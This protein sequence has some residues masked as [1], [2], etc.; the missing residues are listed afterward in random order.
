[1]C[2]CLAAVAAVSG[3]P[4]VAIAAAGPAPERAGPAAPVPVPHVVFVWFADGGAPP[5]SGICGPAVPPPFRCTFAASPAACAGAVTRELR[6]LYQD[7]DLDFVTTDP[8]PAPH[9]TVVVTSAGGAWCAPAG[10]P[11]VRGVAPVNCRADG[12]FGQTAYVFACDRDAVGCAER[13][14]QE[15]AHLVGLDHSASPADVMFP[16]E[17]RGAE[18][19]DRTFPT[20]NPRC[21]KPT[22]NS[23][24]L[25]LARFGRHRRAR[26]A[27]SGHS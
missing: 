7:F 15:Q 3:G 18:F 17:S 19:R 21:G 16:F 5:A 13:I 1:L 4:M 23:Y 22:Q 2:F 9:F 11:R 20:L 25:M 12:R 10:P 27:V 14:A 26:A 6:R 8:G 24:R